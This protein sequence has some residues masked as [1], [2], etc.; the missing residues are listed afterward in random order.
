MLVENLQQRV[1]EAF[2]SGE[3]L[4]VQSGN[5]KRFLGR[6]PSGEVISVANNTGVV[7]YDPAE[8]VM[9]VKS[10]TRLS[11]IREHLAKHNQ[12]LP[13]DAPQFSSNSTIG[14]AV[15]AGLSGP[16]RPWTG[17]IRDYVL[18]IE[19]IDG[20]GDYLRFGGRVMKNVAGYDASRL[21]V[22][23]MGTLGI[24][25]QVSF[26]VLPNPES[27][28]TLKVQC[29]ESQS[30]EK[31]L[32]LGI[33]SL[34]LSASLWI[35]N[36]LFVRLSGAE[37]AVNNGVELIDW[38]VCDDD[39]LWQHVRDHTHNFFAN[40]DPLWRVSIPANSPSFDQYSKVLV[41]WGGA[42]RWYQTD[43]SE[44]RI[45]EYAKKCGGSAVLFRNGDRQG[46]VN[47][48]LNSVL[49]RFHQQLKQS[50]DPRGILNHGRL[51]ESL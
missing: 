37:T 30:I 3:K 38:E 9:T 11:E 12:Y 15:A 34:P 7:E 29:S 17:S 45:H 23:A 5:S 27:N 19:C 50:F 33:T 36:T 39:S 24:I 20:R 47:G 8:L 48:V 16:V 42:L 2:S 13:F 32:S 14:G 26:K 18:G 1:K 43:L 6:T 10:G 22:G 46:A 51:Y 40:D 31:M 35:D 25:M 28:V 49:L 4:D 21:M 41:E 44:S